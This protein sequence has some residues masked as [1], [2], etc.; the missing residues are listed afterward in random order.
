MA[1][2]NYY[3]KETKTYR[4]DGKEYAKAADYSNAVKT[5]NADIKAKKAAKN[6]TP[7]TSPGF[8]KLSDVEKK[9]VNDHGWTNNGDGTL[10]ARSTGKRY[11]HEA[12]SSFDERHGLSSDYTPA[13]AAT[14]SNTTTTASGVPDWVDSDYGYDVDNP[15]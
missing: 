10:T 6:S 12:G 9:L 13:G 2:E 15:H 1:V 3:D 14:A 4:F 5:Y 11:D 8:D 7:N